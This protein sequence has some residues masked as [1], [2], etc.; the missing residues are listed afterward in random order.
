M[1]EKLEAIRAEARVRLEDCKTKADL[2]EMCIRDSCSEAQI[3]PLSKVLEW[4][5]EFTAS[6]I[7][8]VSSII[9]GVLPAP[10]PRAG[11]PLE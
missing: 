3:I 10:T 9:A 2:E 4:M 7:S 8:A 5:M 1:K 11:V 6:R